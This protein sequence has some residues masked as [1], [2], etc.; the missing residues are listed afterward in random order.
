M[1]NFTILARLIGEI[2]TLAIKIAL[3][4][5]VN[6]VNFVNMLRSLEKARNAMRGLLIDENARRAPQTSSDEEAVATT[7]DRLIS[8]YTHIPTTP[9]QI[10]HALSSRPFAISRDCRQDLAN[11]ESEFK[12]KVGDREALCAMFKEIVH[13]EEKRTGENRASR[14]PLRH[15]NQHVLKG[16]TM[17]CLWEEAIPQDVAEQICTWVDQWKHEHLTDSQLIRRIEDVTLIPRRDD[18]YETV[19][20]A[21]HEMNLD[22]LTMNEYRDRLGQFPSTSNNNNNRTTE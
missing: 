8:F 13:S 10:L 11:Q 14:A 6:E 2:V 19:A 17:R 12:K 15:I 3:F 9:R 1:A 18:Q 7:R 5:D 4:R 21:L 20:R 16:I 22:N